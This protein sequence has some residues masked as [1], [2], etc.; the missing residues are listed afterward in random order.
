[1]RP[2]TLWGLLI[3][4]EIWLYN[5]G[6]KDNYELLSPQ[7]TGLNIEARPEVVYAE[8]SGVDIVIPKIQGFLDEYGAPVDF[9]AVVLVGAARRHGLR[10][11][12]LVLIGCAE[13]SCGKRYR[14][15]AFGWDSDSRFADYE[16]MEQ[17]AEY[18]ASR[19]ADMEHYRQWIESDQTDLDWFAKLFNYPYRRRYAQTLKYF[20][21]RIENQ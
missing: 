18:I 16:T 19:I 11:D 9:N 13:S 15:N 3:L 4:L 21:G 8:E 20:S 17:D 10:P 6:P 5:L 2:I 14:Y 12:L 1:M 7:P